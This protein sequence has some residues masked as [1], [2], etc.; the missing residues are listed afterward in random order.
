MLLPLPY[1]VRR[2]T[3]LCTAVV[4]C[5]SVVNAQSYGEKDQKATNVGRIGL[6]ITNIGVLG[7]SFRGP[8]VTQNQPSCEYPIGTGIEH[9]FDAG[10]WIGADVLG[11]KLVST[12]AAGDDANGYD[13]GN[14][15]YEF[16]SKIPLKERSTLE[17]AQF[18]S[19]QAVSHQDIVAIFSDSSTRI[20]FGGP[21][22]DQHTQP[23][24]ANVTLEAYA[25]NFPFA[26]YFVLLNYTIT[27]SSQNPWKEVYIANWG[28]YIVRN[29]KVNP[30][31]G[32]DRFSH[33]AFGYIDSLQMLYA[34][35][36]DAGPPGLTDSYVSPVLVGGEWRGALINPRAFSSM[37]DSLRFYYKN[38]GRSATLPESLRTFVQFWGFRST[39]LELGSP[40][41]DAERYL[42]MS[43]Q[44][45]PSTY[46][47]QI[48]DKASNLLSMLSFGPIPEV[49]PGESFNV[50]FAV[51]T[52]KKF[53]TRP[54][55]VNDSLSRVNLI[56]NIGW[57]LRAYNGEDANGNGI[58]D[59]GEDSNLNGKLDRYRLPEPP[60][61][62]KMK[63]IPSDRSVTIYWDNRAEASV[64]PISREKDFEGYRVYRSNSG[65][66][67]TSASGSAE[68]LILMAEFDS[69]GNNAG[70]NGGFQSRG[71]FEKLAVPVTFDGDTA[72]KYYYKYQVNNL[73]NGWQYLFSVTS[74]DEGDPL[75]NIA[76]L[77]SSR[78][79]NLA[80]V[81]PGTLV[82][83][84]FQNGKI[85]VYPNPYYSRALWDGT[86]E[87]DKKI[88]FYNLPARSE[89]RIYT[90]AG[91][92][93]DVIQHN[94]ATYK[95]E[96]VR[97]FST[98]S[99]GGNVQMAGGEHAWDMI[100]QRDQSLASG[101]YLFSV[102]DLNS[103][104]IQVGKF[105][106]IK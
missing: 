93:V 103:G 51:V 106:I 5:L 21:V 94:S 86:S 40:K 83:D 89:I 24:Y 75:R 74:F 80:R 48:K 9:L 37:P 18:F 29:M 22:I 95:G 4:V 73:L 41:N 11:N 58:L 82:N 6:T 65:N 90:L 91:E 63:V 50:V 20:P 56:D 7:N 78:S 69:T 38:P 33:S 66:E 72:T 15:G 79:Q 46:N 16:T 42:K 81:I 34:Y 100:S 102:K 101:L 52:A 10:L 99:G 26:E 31:S 64:D 23:L 87:R 71:N 28:D 59:P 53:G 96:D 67:L 88:Y 49:R 2:I 76:S 97:W 77:E 62:P 57:A 60:V 104:E 43:T 17:N 54:N 44:L 12:G 32:T 19:P 47:Q 14:P 45:N 35:D 39:D 30:S 13:P 98:F 27:N 8:F 85:G 55:T 70:S 84:K 61:P 105:V 25:W 3:V 68:S 1:Y 36:Y 92:T